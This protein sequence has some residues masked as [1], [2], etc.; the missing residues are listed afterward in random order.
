MKVKT[1][2]K[3]YSWVEEKKLLMEMCAMSKELSL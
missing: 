2:G 1:T 3:E